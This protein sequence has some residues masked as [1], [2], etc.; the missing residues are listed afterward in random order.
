MQARN[1]VLG[2]LMQGPMSGYDIK[3]QYESRLRHFFNASYGSVYPALKLLEREG[4]L[5]KKL[6][7]QEGKPNKNMFYITETG[8]QQFLHYM[9]TPI[10]EDVVRSD[11][12]ARL[13]FG[14]EI[15]RE[16]LI[17]Q[18]TENVAYRKRVISQ[19]THLYQ[20][21]KDRLPKTTIVS[22]QFG[23]H[24]HRTQ[25]EMLERSIEY[26]KSEEPLLDY[27]D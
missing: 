21:R 14:S 15:S 13:F 20:T 10:E 24:I 23:L 12:S 27:W 5:E 16:Q 1:I 4:L 9:H 6:V 25:V 22:I 26:I 19:L 11:I 2:L 3:Q 18:L 8:K 7:L 17:K